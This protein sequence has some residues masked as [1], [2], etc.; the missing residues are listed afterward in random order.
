MTNDTL[1]QR[2]PVQTSDQD[3]SMQKGS[4]PPEELRRENEYVRSTGMISK[5]VM[6][7]AFGI[8]FIA[9]AV[10][11]AAPAGQWLMTYLLGGLGAVSVAWAILA[12]PRRNR[13]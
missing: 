9:I 11:F 2:D 5:P 6:A 13:V 7:L 8:A 10:A 12:W 1:Q 3:K 4:S